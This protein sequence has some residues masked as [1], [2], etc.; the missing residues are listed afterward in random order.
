MAL[1][2]TARFVVRHDLKDD[3]AMQIVK[4][5]LS[6]FPCGALAPSSV[7]RADGSALAQLPLRFRAST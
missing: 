1:G 4:Y 3:E 6:L 7:Q 2:I 5:I